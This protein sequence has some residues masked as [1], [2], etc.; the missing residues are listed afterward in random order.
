MLISTSKKL[1]ILSNSKC[2]TTSIRAALSKKCEIRVGTTPQLKHISAAKFTKI[3]KPFLS[4]KLGIG[5]LFVIC[6]TRPPTS[7]IISWYKYRSR[8]QIK[9]TKRYLGDTPFKD[10]C[11][12]CMK[13]QADR[14]FFDESTY[15]PWVDIAVPLEKISILEA[16]L[17]K[18][19]NI[20]QIPRINS[21]D[22]VAPSSIAA[23]MDTHDY[24]EIIERELKNA[25]KDFT[26]SMDRHNQILSFFS[27][28]ERR[29]LRSEAANFRQIFERT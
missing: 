13:K 26:K 16:F 19:F 10:F 15:K 20:N 8:G 12:N 7:K 2:G 25:S 24:D 27:S 5:N 23:K 9:G 11:A 6:T 18:E 29:E 17:C 21:S 4:D 22:S 28:S 14:F 3:W 1:V